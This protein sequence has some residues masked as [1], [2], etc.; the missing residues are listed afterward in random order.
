MHD[1]KIT[2]ITISTATA[3][4]NRIRS[5]SSR[6]RSPRTLL[7]KPRIASVRGL[8]R[9]IIDLGDGNCTDRQLCR[10]DP[11]IVL[12]ALRRLIKRSWSG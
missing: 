5:V 9:R 4:A 12:L 3:A 2:T 1:N 6:L 10:D 7:S 11:G 8:L